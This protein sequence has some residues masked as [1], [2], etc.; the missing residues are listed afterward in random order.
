MT[1]LCGAGCAGAHDEVVALA[2]KLKA[3]IVHPLRGKEHVEYDN[4]YDVGMTGLDR[5]RVRLRRD[6]GLRHAA[7]AGDGFSLSAV[8][9]R[10]RANRAGRHPAG[11]AGQPLP[12]D[13]WACW[14]C[15]GH[16]WKRCCRASIEKTD[17]APSGRA[18]DRLQEGAPAR[19]TRWRRAVRDSSIIH[20]QYVDAPGQR[21][22]GRRC[23]LHLRRRHADRLGG[24][25]PQGERQASADRLVQSR[26]D[27]QRDAAG[28]RRAGGSTR[29]ARSSRCR[30]TAASP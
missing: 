2:D 30:A 18:L 24:A 21:A 16:R 7:D 15:Q 8:L 11:S 6:E 23:D 12:A 10:A 14:R 19:S 20:P 28:D 25:L 27:G 22:G 17:S 1:L 3:P 5:L 9:S 29:N 4:P 13:I 26:L